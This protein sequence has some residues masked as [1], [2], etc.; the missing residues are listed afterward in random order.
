MVTDI[1]KHP[2]YIIIN[3]FI[4]HFFLYSRSMDS[5]RSKSTWTRSDQ[6]YAL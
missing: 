4:S 6:V 1:M 3:T 2:V 5:R